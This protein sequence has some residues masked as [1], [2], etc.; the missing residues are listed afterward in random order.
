MQVKMYKIL[1]FVRSF[2]D[3]TLSLAEEA[4]DDCFPTL[5]VDDLLWAETFDNA[6][7]RLLPFELS[8]KTLT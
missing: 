8:V 7:P 4:F 5:A 6:R 3:L 1:T 2:L